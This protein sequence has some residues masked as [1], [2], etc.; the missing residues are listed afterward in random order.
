MEKQKPTRVG[1]ALFLR[2]GSHRQCWP[3]TCY[4]GIVDN[5]LTSCFCLS[6][7]GIVSICYHVWLFH[8]WNISC[9]LPSLPPGLGSPGFQ[10]L[11]LF[12]SLW[13]WE[14]LSIHKFPCFWKTCGTGSRK[15]WKGEYSLIQWSCMSV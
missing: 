2:T 3:W 8:C 14:T 13:L 4:I 11:I 10:E 9:P 7:T 12:R 1:F 15:V 5:Q 6:N